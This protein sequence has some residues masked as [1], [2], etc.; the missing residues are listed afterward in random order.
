[1]TAGRPDGAATRVQI[2]EALEIDPADVRKDFGS[3]RFQE[4]AGWVGFE[5]RGVSRAIWVTG[6]WDHGIPRD[7]A[8]FRG[9]RPWAGRDDGGMRVTRDSE[10]VPYDNSYS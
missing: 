6:W 3:I 8:E 10:A 2:A 5:V 9:L 4:T 1:M 7:G